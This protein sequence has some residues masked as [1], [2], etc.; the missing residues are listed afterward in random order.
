MTKILSIVGARPQFIKA[1]T[2]SRAIRHR[3]E[4]EEL[5]VHTGQH[6]DPNMSGIFFRELEMRE[7][8]HHLEVGGLPHGAMTGRMLEKA[9]EVLIKERPDWVL[10]YGDTNSTLAGAL[11]AAKLHIRT[12]HVEAGLRSF[13]RR[14][15]EE[16]NRTVADHIADVLFAPTDAAISNLQREG[17]PAQR[18]HKVGDVMF[19]A[20]LFSAGKAE[21]VS[22]ILDSLDLQPKEY[23]LATVHREENTDDLEKLAAIFDGLNLV[24]AQQLPIVLPLHPRTLKRLDHIGLSRK[25]SGHI[26]LIEPIGY[27]DMAILT[28]NARIVLTDSGGLQKE[29]FFYRV[30]CVTLRE[31]T[32]WVELVDHGFNRL[33]GTSPERIAAACQLLGRQ[34]L[35]WNVALYG[36]G[37]AAERIVDTLLRLA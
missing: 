29:A 16:I 1:A 32:E 21:R 28:K 2:V 19:D 3:P 13:N 31:E 5:L 34:Q 36:D 11:V 37:K 18:I 12:A 30:P 27:L 23:A 15:P 25:A 4:L 22:R 9:E 10:V 24:A 6:Y 33:S 7:P 35:E 17:I 8:D 20:A 14:M 26:R